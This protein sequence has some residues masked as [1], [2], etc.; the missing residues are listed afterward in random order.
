MYFVSVLCC[1]DTTQINIKQ[2]EVLCAIYMLKSLKKQCY[3]EAL[4]LKSYVKLLKE[5]Y[6]PFVVV[7]TDQHALVWATLI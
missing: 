1:C 7:F 3:V 5:F 4:N 2:F 6:Y